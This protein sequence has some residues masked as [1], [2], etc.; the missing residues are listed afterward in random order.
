MITIVHS[1]KSLFNMVLGL[2]TIL[3][4]LLPLYIFN[5]SIPP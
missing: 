5:N 3:Y 4:A 1:I 2:T